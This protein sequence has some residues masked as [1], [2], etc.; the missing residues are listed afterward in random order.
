MSTRSSLWYSDDLHLYREAFDENNVYPAIHTGSAY[1]QEELILRFRLAAW[2]QMRQYTIE[3]NESY[4]DLSDADLHAE[5]E[6]RV[7]AHRAHLD[8][9]RNSDGSHTGL[10]LMIGSGLFWSAGSSREEMI[11]SF[12]EFYRPATADTGKQL[13]E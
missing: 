9:V 4:L 8:E 3:P 6:R 13:R 12:I 2:K 11:N 7:D 1:L 10:R 5:A